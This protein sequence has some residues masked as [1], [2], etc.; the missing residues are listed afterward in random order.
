MIELLRIDDRLIHA[1]VVIGW[2]RVMN[3]DRIVVADD[4]VAASEWER[5]LYGTAV[6]SDIKVS[7]LSLEET[8]RR[9]AG[10]VFDKEKVILLVREPGSVLALVDLGLPVELVNVGGLHYA[11]GKEKIM[12]DVYLDAE[13]R[14][15]MREL[16]KR[17]IRLEAQALPD[18]DPVVLNSRVV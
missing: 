3:P 2:G 7:I 18:R 8:A 17:G 10:G 11:E 13:E 16:V 15:A 5:N 1:Q 6:P 4:E 14:R 9:A 12:D